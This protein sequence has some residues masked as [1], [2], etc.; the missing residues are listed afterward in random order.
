MH[1]GDC[2]GYYMNTSIYLRRKQKKK[3]KKKRKKEKEEEAFTKI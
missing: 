1:A 3:R 2:G